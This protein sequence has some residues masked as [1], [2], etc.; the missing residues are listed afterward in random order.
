MLISINMDNKSMP[1]A[2]ITSKG[3]LFSQGLLSVHDVSY[4]M[5]TTWLFQFFRQGPS[6]EVL[7]STH[8]YIFLTLEKRVVLLISWS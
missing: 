8:R 7:T 3:E 5:F 6:K 1:R 2:V 4:G